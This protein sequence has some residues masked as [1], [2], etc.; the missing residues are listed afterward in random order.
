VTLQPQHV[1]TGNTRHYFGTN[2]VEAPV[3]A[4]LR[5]VQYEGEWGFYLFYCDSERASCALTPCTYSRRREEAGRVRVQ[6]PTR[7]VGK[8]IAA[9]C[10]R[11]PFLMGRS[12][13]A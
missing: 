2:R 5:I 10:A 13:T 1:P 6:R 11:D 3:P 12:E 9:I 4:L 7:R 8:R